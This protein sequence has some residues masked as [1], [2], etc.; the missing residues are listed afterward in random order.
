MESRLRSIRVRALFTALSSNTSCATPL[1]GNGNA[2][3]FKSISTFPAALTLTHR[4]GKREDHAGDD[5]PRSLW[6][7]RALYWNPYG[8]LRRPFALVA[9]SFADRCRN[10]HER[11]RQL[12]SGSDRCGAQARYPG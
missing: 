11:G 5:P 8:A 12:C 1:D 6:L 4:A 9:L 7:A 3:R 2:A 10:N